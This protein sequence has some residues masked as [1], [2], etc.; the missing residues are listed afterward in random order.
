MQRVDD[1]GSRVAWLDE[2]SEARSNPGTWFLLTERQTENSAWCFVQHI[3]SGKKAAFRPAGSFDAVSRGTG[4]FI[5]AKSI[6][7]D[8]A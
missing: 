5:A 3:K 7:E 4:V 1:P 6:G 2:V 8:L